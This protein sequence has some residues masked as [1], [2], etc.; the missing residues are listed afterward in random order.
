MP[1]AKGCRVIASDSIVKKYHDHG[2]PYKGKH[3]IGAGL[4][5]QR[6]SPLSWWEEW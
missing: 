5:V 1:I 4:P 6:F 3:L 2:N